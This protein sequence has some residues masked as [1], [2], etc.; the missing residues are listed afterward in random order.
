VHLDPVVLGFV[1]TA[2][3]VLVAAEQDDVGDRAVARQR[4]QVALQVGVHALLLDLVAVAD[5]H[6]E[7]HLDVRQDAQRPVLGGGAGVVGAVVP[8]DPQHRQA[9]LAGGLP[10]DGLDQPGV[11]DHEGAARAVVGQHRAGRPQQVARVDEHCAPVHDPPIHGNGKADSSP[12]TP[13]VCA[14]SVV[15]QGKR[16]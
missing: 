9:G 5:Q 11:V 12:A 15:C 3:Q 6:T 1:Q 8:E 16:E 13:P 4:G 7:P 10:D 2:P 14:N